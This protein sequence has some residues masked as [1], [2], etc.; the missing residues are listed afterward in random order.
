MSG[1]HVDRQPMNTAVFERSITVRD[2]HV[3]AAVDGC[4]DGRVERWMESWKL[5]VAGWTNLRTN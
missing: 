1:E 3:S 4:V 5:R 2:G